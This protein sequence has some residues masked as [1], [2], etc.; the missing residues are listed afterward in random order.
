MTEALV[1]ALTER[2]PSSFSTVTESG[3]SSSRAGPPDPVLFRLGEQR[4]GNLTATEM[5]HRRGDATG[6]ISSIW[7]T[8][9]RTWSNHRATVEGPWLGGLA[10]ADRVSGAPSTRLPFHVQVACW[11]VSSNCYEV[12]PSSGATRL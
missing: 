10:Q 12:T 6:A 11:T 1:S 3:V 5:A 2:A 9:K 8:G 4:H 7:C